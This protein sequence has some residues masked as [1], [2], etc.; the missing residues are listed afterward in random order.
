MPNQML[1]KFENSK[2]TA[3]LKNGVV[4]W[5]IPSE[6]ISTAK[7]K[8]IILEIEKD[9]VKQAIAACKTEITI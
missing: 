2:T 7:A 8:E 5:N 3:L 9:K 6:E 1:I 4:Y